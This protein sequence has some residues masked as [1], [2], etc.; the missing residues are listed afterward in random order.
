MIKDL[1]IVAV[2]PHKHMLFYCYCYYKAPVSA[3]AALIRIIN[4][5]HQK[6]EVSALSAYLR[7]NKVI[8]VVKMYNAGGFTKKMRVFSFSYV[9]YHCC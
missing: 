3:F 2:K 4:M 6:L 5:R 7:F 1:G 8:S 9:V